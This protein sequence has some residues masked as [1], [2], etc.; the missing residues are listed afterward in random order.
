MHLRK[1]KKPLLVSLAIHWLALLSLA[2][3]LS[4]LGGSDAGAGKGQTLA[5]RIVPALAPDPATEN[6]K[7]SAKAQASTSVLAAKGE[8]RAP[9][10][11]A[12]NTRRAPGLA[13]LESPAGERPRQG[14]ADDGALS[15]DDELLYRLNLARA[16]RAVRESTINAP[17]LRASGHVE[18]QIVSGLSRHDSLISLHRSSGNGALDRDAQAMVSAAARFVM[19][20]AD[21]AAIVVALLYEVPEP[22]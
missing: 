4:V 5:A 13:E 9:R 19:L 6:A 14:P 12:A 20:P 1:W 16:I 10:A 21:A 17:V 15:S 7:V 11:A 8:H 18:L 22:E 3:G 2:G